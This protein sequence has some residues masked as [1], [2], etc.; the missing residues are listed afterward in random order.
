MS[1]PEILS[2]DYTLWK[3]R[4]VIPIVGFGVF[5]L[6]SGDPWFHRLDY[7]EA[8][9]EA[10]RKL[11][12]PNKSHVS[13]IQSSL[14]ETGFIDLEIRPAGTRGFGTGR[15]QPF[16]AVKEIA[17][18]PYVDELLSRVRNTGDNLLDILH[19][20]ESVQ[21]VVERTGFVGRHINEIIGL[22]FRNQKL[23]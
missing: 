11:V 13:K 15:K 18:E 17:V 19:I 12:I 2:S 5:K 3:A 1:N 4:K 9:P 10:I 16:I 23:D 6:L 7:E 8:V 20:P 22:D 21:T 14:Y